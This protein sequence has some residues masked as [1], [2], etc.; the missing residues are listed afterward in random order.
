MIHE[1]FAC[2]VNSNLIEIAYSFKIACVFTTHAWCK[3]EEQDVYL[4]EGGK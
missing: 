4:I 3:W 1:S 2:I